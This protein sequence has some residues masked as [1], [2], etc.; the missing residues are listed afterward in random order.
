VNTRTVTIPT[1]TALILVVSIHKN[2]LERSIYNL[3]SSSFFLQT[4][5]FVKFETMFIVVYN[6]FNWLD[7]VYWICC[8][9][10]LRWFDNLCRNVGL[11]FLSWLLFEH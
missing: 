1:L 9:L 4:I 7:I 2:H 8:V 6:F 10:E 11:F 3:K 5:R